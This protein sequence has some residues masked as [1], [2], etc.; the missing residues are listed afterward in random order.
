MSDWPRYQSHKIVQAAQIVGFI[1]THT[2]HASGVRSCALVDPGDGVAVTF[3][4]NEQ[5]MLD[6][7]AI[8]DYAILYEDEYASISPRLAFEG[9]YTLCQTPAE[10]A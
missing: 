1:R 5:G 8:G 10:K 6:R 9:G 3:M 4:P 7:A 2:G